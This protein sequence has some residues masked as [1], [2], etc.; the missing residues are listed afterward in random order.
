MMIK[1]GTKFTQ[2]QVDTLTYLKNNCRGFRQGQIM[3]DDDWDYVTTL[4]NNA[5]WMLK[6]CL[7]ICGPVEDDCTPEGFFF[8][9]GPDDP[10]IRV[11]VDP[12]IPPGIDAVGVTK[13]FIRKHCNHS[14]GMT[15]IDGKT[16]CKHCG[17]NL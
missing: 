1:K 14:P 2:R 16:I 13:G 12:Y 11:E 5:E 17:E 9:G 7:D 8:F 6:A 4:V 3:S 15:R 10:D